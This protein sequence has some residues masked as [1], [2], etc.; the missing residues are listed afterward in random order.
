[1]CCKGSQKKD[2]PKVCTPEF[3]GDGVK[4]QREILFLDHVIWLA[5]GKKGKGKTGFLNEEPL[6]AAIERARLP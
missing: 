2:G 3:D 1:L 6:G 4:S 5:V